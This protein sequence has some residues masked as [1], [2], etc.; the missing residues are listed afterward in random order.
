MISPPP[1]ALYYYMGRN[2]VRTVF[3]EELDH[4]QYRPADVRNYERFQSGGLEEQ[5]DDHILNLAK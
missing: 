3:D 5:C 4:V 2:G 1:S